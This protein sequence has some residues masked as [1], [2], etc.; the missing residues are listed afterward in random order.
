MC[1][2]YSFRMLKCTKSCVRDTRN[3]HSIMQSMLQINSICDFFCA[4][5]K[6]PLNWSVDNAV[7]EEN[8]S[9]Y[10]GQNTRTRVCT[11]IYI[12]RYRHSN[13]RWQQYFSTCFLKSTI[14]DSTSPA[15]FGMRVYTQCCVCVC[16]YNHDMFIILNID[17]KACTVMTN[18]RKR[19]GETEREKEKEWK[20]DIEQEEP[21]ERALVCIFQEMVK[22]LPHCYSKYRWLLLLLHD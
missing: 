1:V 13:P 3:I 7:G 15:H 17:R 2:T 20:E 6:F 9:L 8:F 19:D 18:G 22:N 10:L 16:M 12:F 21:C 5:S 14:F 11:C 4:H